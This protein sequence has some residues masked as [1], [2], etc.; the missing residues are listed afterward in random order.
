MET[1]KI[2]IVLFALNIRTKSTPPLPDGFIGNAMITS[3]AAAKAVDLDEKP[4]PFC[5]DKV[6]AEGKV[7][8]EQVRSIVHWLDFNK[9]VTWTCLGTSLC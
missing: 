6:E 7:T 2:S 5:V 1:S 3:S 4:F 8:N 9:V